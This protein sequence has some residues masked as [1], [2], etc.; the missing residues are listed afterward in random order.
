[1]YCRRIFAVCT[2]S[3]S[4]AAAQPIKAGLLGPIICGLTFSPG[5][6]LLEDI[7]LAAMHAE[8]PGGHS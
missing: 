3:V 7:K 2:V 4:V 6:F 1:M 8:E 5:S